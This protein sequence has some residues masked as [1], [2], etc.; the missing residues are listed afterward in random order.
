MTRSKET[1]RASGL[2]H[3]LCRRVRSSVLGRHP[4][5]TAQL[6]RCQAVS[7]KFLSASFPRATRPRRPRFTSHA[8]IL[9]SYRHEPCQSRVWH[10]L[11]P[12]GPACIRA[13]ACHLGQPRGGNAY[14][15]VWHFWLKTD[16]KRPA[17]GS[18]RLAKSSRVPFAPGSCRLATPRVTSRGPR[19]RLARA[20]R[21]LALSSAPAAPCG[22]SS[23]RLAAWRL[24][25]ACRA[26][27]AAPRR[28]GGPGGPG[29]WAFLAAPKLG[30]SKRV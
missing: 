20:Y 8:S 16:A 27:G 13:L 18:R 6:E 4:I 10:R 30:S 28:H 25:R 9:L 11:T 1:P 5:T 12:D 17:L 19:S 14:R 2:P 7:R 15:H 29:P 21:L 3:P 22:P 26:F 23:W 24:C